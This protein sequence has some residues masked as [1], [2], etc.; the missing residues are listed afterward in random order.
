MVK[1]IIKIINSPISDNTYRNVI[2]YPENEKLKRIDV[3]T[4]IR[5]NHETTTSVHLRIEKHPL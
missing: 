4:V 5:A 3:S 1:R 2:L